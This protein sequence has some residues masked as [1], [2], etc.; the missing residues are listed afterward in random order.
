[1]NARKGNWT[2]PQLLLDLE[3]RVAEL[4]AANKA[5]YVHHVDFDA[6]NIGGMYLNIINDTDT[7]FTSDTLLQYLLALP[8][9]TK[10]M[11]TGFSATDE[12]II[13]L[14]RVN[15]EI[16]AMLPD[17]GGYNFTTL[18]LFKDYVEPIRS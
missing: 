7:P 12:T 8:E 1:M 15:N 3:A 11:C 17:T 2:I 10:I 14:K 5:T 18:N 9:D 6:S 4:E 13:Y 16:S